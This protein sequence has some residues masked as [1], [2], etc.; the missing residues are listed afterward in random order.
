MFLVI[1]LEDWNDSIG[2]LSIRVA[3][4]MLKRKIKSRFTVKVL[5]I[6]K[7]YNIYFFKIMYENT[8]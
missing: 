5:T 4:V 2:A 6:K 8:L 3:S 1:F 7:I